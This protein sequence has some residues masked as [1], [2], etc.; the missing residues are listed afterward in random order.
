MRIINVPT[1]DYVWVSQSEWGPW[2]VLWRASQPE[3]SVLLRYGWVVQI[4]HGK[5]GREKAFLELDV[6]FTVTNVDT[7]GKTRIT[8]RA[9]RALSDST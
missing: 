5:A 9:R 6:P 2:S 8:F 4:G 7:N 3:L 1:W